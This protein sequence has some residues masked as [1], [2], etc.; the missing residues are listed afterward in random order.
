MGG[1]ITPGSGGRRRE[2]RPGR[3]LRRRHAGQQ[4][5]RRARLAHHVRAGRAGGGRRDRTGGADDRDRLSAVAL[6]GLLAARDD[7]L[8]ARRAGG[9]AAVGGSAGRARD[10]ARRLAGAERLPARWGGVV[11]RA[12]G[13]PS[14]LPDT[15]LLPLP[16]RQPELALGALHDP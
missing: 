11:G 7:G 2:L 5:N 6:P 14:V 15:R 4:R 16:A 13:D 1:W 12:D 10:A 3:L 9:V 8:A